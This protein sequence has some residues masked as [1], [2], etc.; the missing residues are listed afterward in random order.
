MRVHDQASSKVDK[1]GEIEIDAVT[2]QL[3]LIH[4]EAAVTEEGL[5]ALIIAFLIALRAMFPHESMEELGRRVVGHERFRE[6]VVGYRGEVFHDG[7][8]S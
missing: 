3:S 8:K 2:L 1:F 5:L 6:E 7:S 4:A